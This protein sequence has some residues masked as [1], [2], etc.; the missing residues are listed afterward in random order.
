MWLLWVTLVRRYEVL[1]CPI[2]KVFPYYK[3]L[4][5]AEFES[6]KRCNTW[7]VGSNTDLRMKLVCFVQFPNS[8]LLQPF[9]LHHFIASNE[10]ALW[11]LKECDST[12]NY[13]WKTCGWPWQYKS[14]TRLHNWH[15][16]S[17]LKPPKY[18]KSFNELKHPNLCTHNHYQKEQNLTKTGSITPQVG[19]TD[20][21]G[22]HR[23]TDHQLR[24]CQH[25]NGSRACFHSH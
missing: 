5:L 9:E 4:H 16:A 11:N 25:P 20:L 3:P 23:C 13:F 12:P 14:S 19:E 24:W 22:C 17:P 21:P 6:P 18:V 15:S 1:L 2:S 7:N 8:L 10:F